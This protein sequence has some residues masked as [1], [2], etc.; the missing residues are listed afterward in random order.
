MDAYDLLETPEQAVRRARD[1]WGDPPLTAEGLNALT[2][3]AA[4][5]LPTVIA[6]W[7]RGRLRALRQN[8]LRH[9]LATSPDLQTS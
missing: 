9:L 3:F 6:D 5:C 8:A 1:F 4:T 2:T 7:E